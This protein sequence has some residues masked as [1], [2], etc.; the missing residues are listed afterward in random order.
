ME[1]QLQQIRK[2]FGETPVLKDVT[3][4]FQDLRFT[5]ILGPSGC[6]KTTLLRV[7]AGLEKPDAGEISF[8]GACVFSSRQ[9]IDLPPYRRGIGMVFQDFAL[10]PHM[11]VF[12]NVAFPLRAAGRNGEIRTKVPEALARVR[13][14][15]LEKRYPQELSGGQQQRVSIARAIVGS[16]GLL[17]FDEPFSSLDAKLREEMRV[18]LLELVKELHTTTVFVTHDQAEAMSMADSLLVLQSGRVL[19]SGTPEEL[20]HSPS[21]RFVA[22]FFGNCNCLP[23]GRHILRPEQARAENPGSGELEGVVQTCLYMGERYELHVKVGDALW[24]LYSLQKRQAGESVGISFARE[25]VIQI[26]E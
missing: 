7:L 2:S 11:T 6:G 19:Q 5:A 1:I 3:V 17:L 15:G 14:S 24:R 26:S 21:N 22:D 13:L 25:D 23:D 16:P 4:R 12:E 18:E 9:G 10:W 8:N 20:Y